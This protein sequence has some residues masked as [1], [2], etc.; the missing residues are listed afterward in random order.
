MQAKLE[1]RAVAMGFVGGPRLQRMTPG[2]G[3][4]DLTVE[5]GQVSKACREIA[6][7]IQERRVLFN[8]K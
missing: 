2:S 8:Y 3:K 6:A 1:T 7:M 4:N 5:T